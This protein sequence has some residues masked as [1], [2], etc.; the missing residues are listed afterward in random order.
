MSRSEAGPSRRRRKY[1]SQACNTCRRRK[2]KCDGAQP[3]CQPCT[4][5]GHECSWSTEGNESNR[6]VTKQY[7]EGLRAKIQM[8]ES[9]I[10]LLKQRDQHT[11][12]F[13]FSST[14]LAH[15]APLTPSVIPSSIS[16]SRSQSPNV[17]G[18]L[19]LAH[20]VNQSHFPS[21]YDGYTQSFEDPVVESPHISSTPEVPPPEPD[22]TPSSPIYQYIFNLD[23]SVTLEEQSPEHRASI[24]H[25]HDT[26][27]YR[28]FSYGAAWLLGMIPR[29][30][31]H[32]MLEFLRPGST[33]VR[34][35]LK[36]YSPLLHCSLLAF[37]S[38]F[39]D[40]AGIRA[41]TTRERF[42]AH[43]KQWLDEEFNY[44][45]P[46]LILSLVLLS[47]YH[48]GIGEMNT[49][50]MYIGMSMR[51]AQV[52][53]GPASPVRNWYRWS[54]FIQEKLMALHMRRPSEMP[55][56]NA[57]I[58]LPIT[59]GSGGRS[60][61]GNSVE[62]MLAHEDYLGILVN[63]FIQSVRLV[64]ISSTIPNVL[65]SGSA[66][67][68]LHIQLDSWFNSLQ[69]GLLIRQRAT[70]TQPPIL[71]LHIRYWWSILDLHLPFIHKSDYTAGQS[72]KM[73]NRATEKLVKLFGAYDTQFGFRYF[74][75]NLL[76]AMHTCGKVLILERSESD[77]K[78]KKRATAQD[79]IEICLKGL[80]TA[81]ETWFEGRTLTTNLETLLA[82]SDEVM[83][84]GT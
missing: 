54:T 19:S 67:I 39:S 6:P 79:G 50:Y 64:L 47:E 41:R 38:P 69:D 77:G 74:P 31:L 29:L 23:P 44:S 36:H 25:E 55:E 78:L 33:Q 60:T 57:P 4:T 30:F 12:A 28:G 75:R 15:D 70:L 84:D 32:D 43:A 53:S 80:R 51:A 76:Q 59:I 11:A 66:P 46:S 2:T 49:G 3:I 35:G 14:Q 10:A 83:V 16:P 5:S 8:L 1:A 63:C 37:A 82:A 48:L 73:C 62:D 18:D 52:R 27:L 40:N 34:G 26:L 17:Q 22:D 21:F 13:P 7:V 68:D 58:L 9:E 71:A 81:G 65:R 45:N 61:T 56:P 20:Y 72:V 24:E 42:A